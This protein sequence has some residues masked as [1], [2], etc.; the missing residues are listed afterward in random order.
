MTWDGVPWAVGGGAKHSVNIARNVAHAAFGGR[1]GVVSP[2]DLEVR[3][4]DVP[5]TGVQVFPGTVAIANRAA[6][7]RD[8]MYVA[9]LPVTDTV[10]IT[11][12]DSTGPRSDLIVARVENSN[13]G[14]E[15]W[16]AP[17][18]PAVG[19]YIFT[20]V[21]ENVPS[22]TTSVTELGLGYSAFPLAL[23]TLPASTGTVTQAMVT[24]LR[25]LSQPRQ[26]RVLNLAD[27][28]ATPQDLTS[29]SFTNWPNEANAWIDVPEWA[30]HVKVVSILAGIGIGAAGNN[31]GSGWNAVG[32]LRI[33]IGVQAEDPNYSQ[34]V[35]YNISH[36]SGT[37]RATIMCGANNLAI[38]S[39]LRGK[40]AYIRVEGNKTAGNDR[41]FADSKSVVSLDVEFVDKPESN[42]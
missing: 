41:L 23:V 22:T 31:G 3:E 7:A 24:D 32:Q 26:S 36:D 42:V 37:D 14:S 21:I 19:P 9:R 38:P 17:A 33:Q 11:A 29:S 25:K 30:T 28:F 40:K 8:E 10:N 16:S 13:I 15:G 27:T 1:E 2:T 4:L 35:G 5:G 12:T 20:R 18:D 39:D 6:G 34:P